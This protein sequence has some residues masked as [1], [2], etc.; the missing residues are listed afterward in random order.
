MKKP[1]FLLLWI[2]LGVLGI[3]AASLEDACSRKKIRYSIVRPSSLLLRGTTNVNKFTCTCEEQFGFQELEVE[4]GHERSKFQ[5]ARLS[6]A[7]RKFN[8]RNGQMER[9]LQRALKSE[10]HPRILIDL[11]EARYPPEFLKNPDAGWFDV[12]ARVS[13]TI[14]GT[15]KEKSLQA[16]ATRLSETK[17]ALK[18]A[19][20]IRMTEF[21]IEPPT[22]MFGLIQVDDQITFHF[23]LTV[24]VE[25]VGFN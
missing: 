7:T 8:C 14:A 24:Q 5:D 20:A 12:E 13:L 22:A 6:M 23:D 11:V 19:R 16:Q 25:P 2:A 15:T 3:S 4:I 10:A 21:G 1:S 18:G 9:D 17:F